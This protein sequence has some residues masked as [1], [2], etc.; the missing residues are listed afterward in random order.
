MIRLPTSTNWQRHVRVFALSFAGAATLASVQALAEPTAAERSLAAA[1]FEQGRTL[2][3]EG[4][5]DEACVKL[6]ESQRRD[7]GGGT[8]LN[9]A[10]CHEKQGKIATA[11][12]EFRDA[13]AIAKRDN[14]PDR[15][16]AADAEIAKLEPQ[17]FKISVVVAP[18]AKIPGMIVE[19]EGLILPEEAWGTPFPVDP[20]TRTIIV[21]AP[22]YREWKG[23][24]EAG[25]TA[26]TADVNIPKLEKVEASV[27]NGS[28]PPNST[29]SSQPP[30]PPPPTVKTPGPDVPMSS[31]RK[32]GFVVGGLGLALIGVGAITGTIAIQKDTAA[33]DAGCDDRY[34]S[35]NEALKKAQSAY[36][37]ANVS[38]ATFVLGLAGITAGTI[39]IV[40]APKNAPIQASISVG[41]QFISVSG[42]F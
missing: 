23:L 12:T 38:T 2:M 14:R 15:E 3:A 17:L 24:V 20:G 8:L 40:A 13:R 18:E 6:G 16:S 22:G 34:C 39:M 26:G 41:P 42:K 32:G 21:K 35:D 31:M 9:L 27:G 25:K 37:Y 28:T 4:R 33:D 30:P 5:L 29:A 7:P 36:Q 11:W 10:L 1:L 19:V